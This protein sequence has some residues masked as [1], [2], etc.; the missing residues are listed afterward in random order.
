MSLFSS[1]LRP[2]EI[3]VVVLLVVVLVLLP[4]LLRLWITPEAPWYLPYLVWGLIIGLAFW[5]QRLLGR[6]AV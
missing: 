1:D 5:L 2:T 6:H 4:P 3:T